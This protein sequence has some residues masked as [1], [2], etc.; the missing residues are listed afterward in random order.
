MTLR[1]ALK[2]CETRQGASESAIATVESALGQR[3]PEDYRRLLAESDGAEGF[4]ASDAY[5][6]LWSTSDLVPLNDAYSVAEFLP[7]AVLLGTDGADTGYGFRIS[8]DV[9]EYIAVPL[10]GMTADA[11]TSAGR[12]VEELV[13][14]VSSQ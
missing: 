13:A 5:I 8:D 10:V 7:G 6:S 4:V 12:T 1:D 9:V 11:V 2:A 3:L 14:W